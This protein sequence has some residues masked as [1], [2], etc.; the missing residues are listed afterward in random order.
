MKT[1]D[2]VRHE[3]PFTS[4]GDFFFIY[5]TMNRFFETV[6]FYCRI[7][8]L[9]ISIPVLVGIATMWDLPVK[10]RFQNF[11]YMYTF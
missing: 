10:F 11:V 5:K 9:I 3:W 6:I 8:I 7:F 1:K 4:H 2:T